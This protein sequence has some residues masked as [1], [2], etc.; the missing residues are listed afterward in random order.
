MVIVKWGSTTKEENFLDEETA[1][2]ELLIR[3]VE[4]I[5]RAVC[6]NLEKETKEYF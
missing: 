1:D 5:S 3:N 4:K 2:F 6:T